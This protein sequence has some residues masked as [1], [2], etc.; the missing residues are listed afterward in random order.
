MVSKNAAKRDGAQDGKKRRTFG[1]DMIRLL[2]EEDGTD[3]EF[4]F[5]EEKQSIK[6]HK[7]I[8]G[9]RSPVLKTMFSA[10]MAENIGG[11]VTVE[12]ASIND[13]R[14]FLRCLYDDN[15]PFSGQSEQMRALLALAHKYETMDLL[16]RLQEPLKTYFEADSVCEFLR[17]AYL[18]RLGKLVTDCHDW[19]FGTGKV[20]NS[21][22]YCGTAWSTKEKI[23]CGRSPEQHKREHVWKL[24]TNGTS[25]YDKVRASQSFKDLPPEAVVAL[26]DF[27]TKCIK[28]RGGQTIPYVPF[29]FDDAENA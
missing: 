29:S 25:K 4:Y 11:K 23:Y 3:F 10:Q 13:F 16:S 22:G 17:L 18:F 2:I 27:S 1:S 5:P 12:D 15:E 24:G 19:I 26:L 7:L 28:E 6:A 20:A 14:K 21:C 9:A 8:L